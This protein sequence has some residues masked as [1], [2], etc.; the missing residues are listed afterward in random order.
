[1]DH[2]SSPAFLQ[3]A[4]SRVG[5]LIAAHDW[6]ATSLGPMESWPVSLRTTLATMM[7]CPTAMFLAWGPELVC[8]YND[9]YQEVMSDSVKDGIGQPFRVLWSSIWDEIS[10][11]VE[12]ALAGRNVRVVDMRLVIPREGLPQESF[13]TFSYSPAFDDD[14]RIAGM[15]CVT[16]ETTARVVAER[17][18]RASEE[19]LSMALS[20]GRGIGIWDW[21]V[22][23]DLVRADERFA[24]LYGVEPAIAAAGAPLTEFFRGIHPEDRPRLIEEI[25][26]ALA[27]L[28]DAPGVTGQLICVDGGQHL[29]WQTPDV[30]GIE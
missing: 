30:L 20:A 11:L 21:D 6:S 22:E 9:A 3:P 15:F 28:L 17:E 25:A 12:T 10:P 14:G 19:R 24:V 4:T 29:A 1:M 27:Y 23:N 18:S 2:L 26:A 7:A 13:W 8:F 16:M 5:A